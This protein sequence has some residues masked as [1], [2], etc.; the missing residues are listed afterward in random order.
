MSRLLTEF[1]DYPAMLS[2]RPAPY[3][4]VQVAVIAA[5][6]S[7]Q[8]VTLDNTPALTECYDRK[9]VAYVSSDTIANVA[10]WTERC[11]LIGS[12]GDYHQ[13]VHQ[14]MVAMG[15]NRD[16]FLPATN[17][18]WCDMLTSNSKH[19]HSADGSTWTQPTYYD[20]SQSSFV[21]LG[22]S[23]Q[24]W[25]SGS[26][27]WLSFWGSD[28]YQGGC[29]SSTNTGEDAWKEDFMMYSC[30]RCA[31]IADW[32]SGNSGLTS[33]YFQTEVCD[34]NKIPSSAKMIRVTVG[35]VVDYF[36]PASATTSL[37]DMLKAKNL[38]Q[39]S[40]DGTNWFTPNYTTS[41][42]DLGG[43]ERDW[44]LTYA[45][46]DTREYLTFWGSSTQT[47]ACCTSTLEGSCTDPTTDC[48]DFEHPMKMEYCREEMTT[49]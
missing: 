40:P 20:E 47:G 22:G 36:K 30:S 24:D 33:S 8:S 26:R 32:S 21:P 42:T 10:F 23:A 37:C 34:K 43:S 6:A 27:K 48:L 45:D 18:N 49:R 2:S 9:E 28:T 16:F 35:S 11:K 19:W 39:W 25:P 13:E 12:G 14:V 1:V 5:V 38:H 44:P 7:S 4:V 3:Q 15:S 17:M 31:L 41:G 29:C 46:G